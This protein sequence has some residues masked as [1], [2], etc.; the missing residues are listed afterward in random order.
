MLLFSL[1]RDRDGDRPLPDLLQAWNISPSVRT[2]AASLGHITRE[3]TYTNWLSSVRLYLGMG[4]RIPYLEQN[5]DS[6]SEKDVKN[7]SLGR[8][9]TKPTT[10]S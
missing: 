1:G 9:P 4:L 3:M 8:E 6:V 10:I 2:E 5:R 7:G